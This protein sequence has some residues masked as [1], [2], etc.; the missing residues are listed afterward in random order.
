MSLDNI[1]GG[2]VNS[3]GQIEGANYQ[4]TGLA[5]DNNGCIREGYNP[6]PVAKIDSGGSIRDNYGVFTEVK[7]NPLS[8]VFENDVR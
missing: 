6:V 5:V 3:L 4:P 8:R 2:S 7:L 1:V